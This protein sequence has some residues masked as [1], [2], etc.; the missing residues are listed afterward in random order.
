VL[1]GLATEFSAYN[2]LSETGR[3]LFRGSWGVAVGRSFAL[4]QLR[5]LLLGG[6]LRTQRTDLD[7]VLGG[8]LRSTQSLR[9]QTDVGE[10]G[11]PSEYITR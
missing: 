9:L 11:A 6:L 2:T 10:A 7:L 3:R 1:R 4:S 5:R 8:P